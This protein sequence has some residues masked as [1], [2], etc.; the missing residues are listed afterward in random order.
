MKIRSLLALV[1]LAISSEDHNLPYWIFRSIHDHPRDALPL[2]P[3][4]G[5]ETRWRPKAVATARFNHRQ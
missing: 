4:S 3:F 5:T 2:R 1:G